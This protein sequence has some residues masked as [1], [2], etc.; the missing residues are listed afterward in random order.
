MTTS[1]IW[2]T[3]PAA[4][5]RT[6]LL[7]ANVGGSPCFWKKR[8]DSVALPAVPPTRPVK[9]WAYWTTVTGRSGRVLATAPS[10]AIAWLR[11]GSWASTAVST[12]HSQIAPSKTS[13]MAATPASC[14]TS[15]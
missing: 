1:T 11:G 13:P 7:T 5:L 6:P 4:E 8:I 14:T 9:D 12:T 3:N 10:M 15:R 2:T